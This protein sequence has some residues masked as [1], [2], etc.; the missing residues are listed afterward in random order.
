V[1]TGG[2]S[3]EA[4][5]AAAAQGQEEAQAT[6]PSTP[7]IAPE[8]LPLEEGA[9][10]PLPSAPSTDLGVSAKPVVAA[11][12]LVVGDEPGP[13]PA[14][15]PPEEAGSSVAAALV[16]PRPGSIASLAPETWAASGQSEARASAG[17]QVAPIPI[18][19]LGGGEIAK[20]PEERWATTIPAFRGPEVG[21]GTPS[22]VVEVSVGAVVPTES[23]PL[24]ARAAEGAPPEGSAPSSPPGVEPED[25]FF[26]APVAEGAHVDVMVARED[27]EPAQRGSNRVF[28]AVAGV[29]ALAVGFFLVYLMVTRDK[30]E[31]AKPATSKAPLVA[32]QPTAPAPPAEVP[33]PPP[34]APAP[35]VT[36]P[37]P[38]PA[39]LPD[40]G[41]PVSTA[42]QPPEEPEAE[43]EEPR[44]KPA[45]PKPPA[46]P[47]KPK[48]KAVARP[49]PTPTPAPAPAPAPEDDSRAQAQARFRA[50]QAL[51][52]EGSFQAAVAEFTQA[53]RLNRGTAEAHRGLGVAYSALQRKA[54]AIRH[55]EAY[56]RARPKAPDREAVREALQDLRQ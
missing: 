20:A 12:V 41:L 7:N 25:R 16:P 44:P 2:Y 21:S 42:P 52:M 14:A 22:R 6:A 5:P 38:A 45:K 18:T 40:A 49:E 4:P 27:L 10:A 33:P 36:P 51:L 48:E 17:W 39:A 31:V 28:I 9:R 19:A 32:S 1:D 34:P 13:P 47:K 35:A 43:V 11:P 3:G 50:G 53:L 54:E 8:A 55:Y 30:P 23:A 24:Q 26:E 37:A 56:L 46:K 15:R 29:V